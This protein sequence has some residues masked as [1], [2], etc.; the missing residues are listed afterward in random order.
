MIAIVLLLQLVFSYSY[1]WDN[2]NS[3]PNKFGDGFYCTTVRHYLAPAWQLDSLNSNANVSIKSFNG[4]SLYSILSLQLNSLTHNY[5]NEEYTFKIYKSTSGEGQLFIC[6]MNADGFFK[7]MKTI[8][9]K[10][11]P[12]KKWITVYTPI[13][14]KLSYKNISFIDIRLYSNGKKTPKLYIDNNAI[15]KISVDEY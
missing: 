2:A 7:V 12:K 11:I 10:D 3:N 9:L 14:E 1:T 8:N 5:K 4:D 13:S 6:N 15:S